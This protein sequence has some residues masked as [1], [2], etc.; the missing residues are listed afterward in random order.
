MK[1]VVTK[2]SVMSTERKQVVTHLAKG[3]PVGTTG[4]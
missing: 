4:R 3:N 2:V 1:E